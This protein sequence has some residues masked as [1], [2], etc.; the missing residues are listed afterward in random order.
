MSEGD[1]VPTAGVRS[2]LWTRLARRSRVHAAWLL[3]TVTLGSAGLSGAALAGSTGVVQLSSGTVTVSLSHATYKKLTRSTA[4]AYPDTRSLTAIAPGAS[5]ADG[6]FTFPISRG[7]VDPIGLTG[8]A[9]STGGIK[10]DSVSQNPA[11][12]QTSTVQFQLTGFALQLSSSPA[13]LTATFGGKATYRNIPIASLV[14]TN[15]RHRV[16]GRQMTISG[17]DLVLLA[18]GAQLFNQQA[19]NNQH[20]RFKTGQSIGTLSL[21]ASG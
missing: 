8:T 12:N 11:L 9:A 10:F 7:R 4:G 17:L 6:V 19:F 21:T 18:A 5:T 14:T 16:H 13:E 15:V 1:P 2:R 20:H 3:G